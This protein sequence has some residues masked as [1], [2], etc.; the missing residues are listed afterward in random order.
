[1]GA[2]NCFW[3]DRAVSNEA[4][5]CTIN[6][7]REFQFPQPRPKL[8]LSAT[9]IDQDN[10]R[11][12]LARVK[13]AAD[14]EE[15]FSLSEHLETIEIEAIQQALEETRWNKTAAAK[16]LGMSFRSLRYRLKKLGLE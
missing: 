9:H 7:R 13:G 10:D 14:T 11:N 16:K 12:V 2:G 6:P 3:A 1:M 8:T 5:H 4:S 15:N